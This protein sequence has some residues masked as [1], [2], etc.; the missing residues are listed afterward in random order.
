MSTAVN[1][2]TD[3]LLIAMVILVIVVCLAVVVVV[4]KETINYLRE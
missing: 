3:A 1:V 2:A 4:I